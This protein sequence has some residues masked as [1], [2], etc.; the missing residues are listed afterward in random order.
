MRKFFVWGGIFVATLFIGP[1]NA[2]GVVYF[3]L[4][5]LA[6]YGLHSSVENLMACLPEK[7]EHKAILNR[8]LPAFVVVIAMGAC[9]AFVHC[10][11]GSGHNATGAAVAESL[12]TVVALAAAKYIR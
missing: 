7:F 2:A 5:L 10:N 8:I 3:G 12:K 6:V 1:T 9:V 4:S 11:F